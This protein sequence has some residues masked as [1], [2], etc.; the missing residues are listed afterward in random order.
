M[1]K[2]NVCLLFAVAAGT[3]LGTL[4]AQSLKNLEDN[5][6]FKK[7]KLGSP[8]VIGMGVKG[9]AE[10]GAD[11]IV[12]DYL[13]ETIGDIPVRTI[14]LFYLRD[15]LSK[16]IVRVPAENYEK[17]LGAC[18]NSFG[19][20]TGNLSDNEG[21][22]KSGGS[23]APVS[24]YRD[25]YVWNTKKISLEY[26]YLYPVVSGGYGTRELRLTYTLGDY[27]ARQKRTGKGSYNPK[28]F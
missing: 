9:K 2:K 1:T 18:K 23:T 22:R 14:E 17:L 16:I 8:Y 11:R 25:Q 10:D 20:P 13:Q 7:Y 6:G 27:A 4:H 28:D 21:T 12:I 15:T 24:L 26:F 5:N 3:A 19:L